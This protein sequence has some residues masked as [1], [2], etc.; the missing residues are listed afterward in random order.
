MGDDHSPFFYP[1]P[2]S[3]LGNQISISPRYNRFDNW[4]K[5]IA[6]KLRETLLAKCIFSCEKTIK[7]RFLRNY[8]NTQRKFSRLPLFKRRGS[9]N[10]SNL[11]KVRNLGGK[12]ASEF[13]CIS[14]ELK[15]V[16]GVQG[17]CKST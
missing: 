16:V 8:I 13:L 9:S 11:Q 15:N 4:L 2:E 3:G 12:S 7:S 17:S 6:R 14:G 5:K 10:I 1:N